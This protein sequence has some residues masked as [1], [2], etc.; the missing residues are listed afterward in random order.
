MHG[1]DYARL[2]IFHGTQAEKTY[3]ALLYGLIDQGED[4]ESCEYAT[5]VDVLLQAMNSEDKRL[6]AAAGLALVCEHIMTKAVFQ[7]FNDIVPALI[8]SFDTDLVIN[9]HR[10]RP[11]HRNRSCNR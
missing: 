1:R 2:K 5:M 10:T 8:S 4:T 11:R 6:R 9:R 7:H 3:A